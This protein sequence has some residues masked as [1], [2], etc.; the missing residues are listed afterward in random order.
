[1]V[2]EDVELGRVL[3]R[4][5][6]DAVAG[7]WDCMAEVE[8]CRRIEAA[9]EALMDVAAVSNQRWYYGHVG[10]ICRTYWVHNISTEGTFLRPN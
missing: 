1:M 6:D 4:M 2:L 9:G 10:F 5:L 7:L 3:V 8:G